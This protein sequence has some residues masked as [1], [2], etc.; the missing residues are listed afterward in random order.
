MN[1]P[2][3]KAAA[4]SASLPPPQQPRGHHLRGLPRTLDNHNDVTIGSAPGCHIVIDGADSLHATLCWENGAWV[5]HDDPAPAETLVNNESVDS[6]RLEDGDWIGIAGVRIQLAGNCLVEAPGDAP[7]G[8][9]VKVAGVSAEVGGKTLLDNI[10]FETRPGRFVVLLGPSGCG[11]STLLQRIAG[12]A[13]SY[14]GDIFL[15]GKNL[16]EAPKELRTRIAYLPQAV[17]DTLHG[18]MT[19]R[20]EMEN[21]ARMF[22]PGEKPDFVQKLAEVGLP[23]SKLDVRTENG[24]K[25]LVAKL[26][27]GE[28]RR[29]ALALALMRNP[30]LLLLDEPTAGLDPA[31]ESGIMELLARLAR[32]GRTVICATHVLGSL[33]LCNEFL[34]LARGGRQEFFGRLDKAFEHFGT[35][36]WLEVYRK[37]VPQPEIPPGTQLSRIPGITFKAVFSGTLLRLAHGVWRGWNGMLFAGIPLLVAAI[38]TWACK[39]MF[40]KGGDQETICF[41]M[42]VALF[43]LGLSGTVRNLV[44]E[45][46]PKRCLDRM[47]GMPLAG[48]FAAH[49]AF[50]FG[51]AGLQ[52]F[53]FTTVVF[54]FRYFRYDGVYFSFC[55]APA[56]LFVLWFVAF[57]GGCLGLAVSAAAKKEI[58]AVWA[59]PLVAILALFLSKPVLERKGQPLPTGALRAME[60]IMPTLHTQECLYGELGRYRDK[61]PE[62]NASK[63]RWFL[64]TAAGY[65]LV[66]LPLAFFFQDRRE[67]EWDGR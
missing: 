23:E 7:D 52:A 63:W 41:C 13:T 25:N 29:L 39:P 33:N 14:S 56:F 44:T 2:E 21:F 46:V 54:A 59:L 51:I 49:A 43:W 45:R 62:T 6:R 61:N 26:S 4:D 36:Q 40:G 1:A 30:Q 47:R 11:K 24:E 17:E 8:L 28:K 16:R 64:A 57:A 5:I 55:A 31:S 9:C 42:A 65:P 20:E 58:Q 50:A 48:Y 22:L 53:L 15:N 35:T 67:K 38:L 27:G 18:D 32:Q 10:S 60:R 19:V 66:F 3:D 37:L 12:L 34:V